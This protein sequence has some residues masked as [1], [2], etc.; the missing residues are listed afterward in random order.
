ME[1]GWS[2]LCLRRGQKRGYRGFKVSKMTWSFA[3]GVGLQTQHLG[4]CLTT[5]LCYYWRPHGSGQ[6][7]YDVPN[8]IRAPARRGRVTIWA[9]P[10]AGPK[11]QPSGAYCLL[12]HSQI[13]HLRLT[14]PRTGIS[15]PA[16]HDTALGHT[17]RGGGGEVIGDRRLLERLGRFRKVLDSESGLSGP[18]ALPF[19]AQI[20]DL[21]SSYQG[22][23]GRR[24]R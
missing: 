20:R 8:A 15:W 2:R 4:T 19:Y 17:S 18:P 16:E 9:I 7:G 21:G 14:R 24:A 10:D 11:R 23:K 22:N 12:Q 6:A 5:P 3:K 1:L 13:A